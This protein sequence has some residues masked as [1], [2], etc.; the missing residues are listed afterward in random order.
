MRKIFFILTSI[1]ISISAYSQENII[2]AL[3]EKYNYNTIFCSYTDAN[4]TYVAGYT[5]NYSNIWYP[6][7]MIVAKYL[8]SDLSRVALKEFTDISF[9]LPYSIEL[10]NG[11]VYITGYLQ[12]TVI[13]GF[14]FKMDPSLIT[15][16]DEIAFNNPDGGLALDMT[17]DDSGDIYS[18]GSFWGSNYDIKIRKY[19]NNP[20]TA[21]GL[22]LNLT[23]PGNDYCWDIKS[24]SGKFYIAGYSQSGLNGF[25]GVKAGGDYFVAELDPALNIT[26]F[27][28]VGGSGKEWENDIEIA[29]SAGKIYLTGIT[30]SAD[31]PAA[32]N[33]YKGGGDAFVSVIDI[34]SFTV[35]K[36]MYIGGSGFEGG[37]GDVI[38]DQTT[39]KTL[40]FTGYTESP[41]FKQ[42]LFPALQTQNKGGKDIFLA[43]VD[44]NLTQAVATYIGATGDEN[45]YAIT[46]T[47]ISGNTSIFYAG[48]TSSSESGKTKPQAAILSKID[49]PC[50]QRSGVKLFSSPETTVCKGNDLNVSSLYNSSGFSYT[51]EINGISSTDTGNTLNLTNIQEQKNINLRIN[52]AFDCIV[53]DNFTVKLGQDLPAVQINILNSQ[54]INT[55]SALEYSFDNTNWISCT[56]GITNG[57]NFHTGILTVREKFLPCNKIQKLILAYADPLFSIDYVNEK[58][59]QNVSGNIEYNYDNNFDTP[60]FTGTGIPLPLSP[61]VNVYFRAKATKDFMGSGVSTLIVPPRPAAPQFPIVDDIA[62]TFDWTNEVGYSNIEDYEY[63]KDGGVSWKILE[64]KP[65]FVNEFNY[66][67]GSIAIRV[68][69]KSL[70]NFTGMP[71]ANL[72]TFT[73]NGFISIG[74][75][76]YLKSDNWKWNLVCPDKCGGFDTHIVNFIRNDSIYTAESKFIHLKLRESQGRSKLWFIDNMKQE[77]LVMDLNLNVGDVFTIPSI[78]GSAGAKI[79]KKETLDDGRLVLTSNY[80]L[81]IEGETYYLTFT[82]GIG[83]NYLPVQNKYD[84]YSFYPAGPLLCA[85]NS[86]C[87]YISI[88]PAGHRCRIFQFNFP[89]Q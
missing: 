38:L 6:N 53:D 68:K 75:N 44:L 52:Y 11:S 70:A 80:A 57:V 2:S 24:Y 50:M 69:A 73:K 63:S 16:E 25:P 43:K 29:I 76:P 87:K 78:I 67:L 41:D 62:N 81:Q 36:T 7:T 34:A 74:G 42:V 59:L 31:M 30:E 10:K 40:Y 14:I 86:E 51:W 58:T 28:Y 27:I 83:P 23:G 5:S 26:K 17:F 47:G 89:N 32:V 64:S 56:D 20:M 18:C 65:L 3:Y 61:G 66:P 82:E 85:E 21:S 49:N 48:Q 22:K 54:I 72:T 9:A 4:Y 55:T 46:G 1:I 19:M 15:V 35:E 79:V 39:G 77:Y 33:S 8:N 13:K 12:G 37:I 45:A 60:N 88:V 84:N 71:S